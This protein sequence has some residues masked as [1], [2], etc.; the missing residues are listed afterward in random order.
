MHPSEILFQGQRQPLLLPACDHYAGSEKLMR[1]SMALQ[2]ELGPVFDITF[3]CEDGAAAGKEREHAE[4]VASLLNSDDNRFGRIGARLHDV[5]SD[6][7]EQDVGIIVGSAAH[8]LAYVALPKPN[9][10]ADVLRAQQIVDAAAAKAGRPH[11]PLHVLIETHGALHEVWE[12][13][14]LP[15]VECLSFGIMDFVSSHYGAIPGAAMRTPGQFTHPL[16]VRAKLEMVAACHAND[17]V[18]SH[19]V[20]T[21]IKDSAVVANDATR[22]AGEFGFTRMWSIHPD[23]IKPIVK[24]FTPR[25][26]EVNEASNILLEAM[27]ADWGPISHLGRLHD[28]ASYR[29]YWTVLQRAKLAGLALPDAAAAIVNQPESI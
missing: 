20:T 24:A 27:A 23:Q 15:R 21:D 28:R 12:I 13:A 17:I 16:V 9:G 5:G 1:K 26:S 4:L 14:A 18:P 7:F 6:H 2:Q 3:D 19:N 8:K 22:A 25:L 29:Y 10:V 11:L